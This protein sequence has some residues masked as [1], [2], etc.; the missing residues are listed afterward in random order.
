MR[1]LPPKEIRLAQPSFD[2]GR[3]RDPTT[4]LTTPAR[5]FLIR[6]AGPACVGIISIL[7][8]NFNRYLRLGR[9]HNAASP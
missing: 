1:Y 5:R 4:C 8:I 7:L 3:P 6:I 9:Q 2:G